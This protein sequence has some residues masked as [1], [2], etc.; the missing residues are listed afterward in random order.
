M[1][2]HRAVGLDQIQFL[3]SSLAEQL[4]NCSKIHNRERNGSLQCPALTETIP[5]QFLP[6][7]GETNS[8]AARPAGC[9]S[10]RVTHTLSWFC[11]VG[12]FLKC[13]SGCHFSGVRVVFHFLSDDFWIWLWQKPQVRSQAPEVR[14]WGA[15]RKAPN[16]QA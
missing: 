5:G 7:A 1:K 13:Q 10:E 15:V 6:G 14:T 9:P 11:K 3:P 16:H 12:P 4:E 8:S 2:T